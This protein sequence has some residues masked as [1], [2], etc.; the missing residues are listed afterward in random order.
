MPEAALAERNWSEFACPNPECSAF[1][2]RGLASIRPHGWSSKAK[3]I[4]CRR[5]TVCRTH[6]SERRGTPFF[7]CQ[8]SPEQIVAIADHIVEGN[9]MRPTSRLCGVSLNTVL[10]IAVR[11]GQ[12][13]EA[14]H[15]Q[16]VRGIHPQVVQ[17]DEAWAFVGKKRETL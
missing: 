14:F 11:A 6:F 10:R 1:G 15:D 9:G 17:G 4:R 8:L 2:R 7:R 5:C 3:G 12:H 13:A 16:K